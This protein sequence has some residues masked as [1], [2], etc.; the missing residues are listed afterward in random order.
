LGWPF[1]RTYRVC[2]GTSSEDWR[3]GCSCKRT[4][5]WVLHGGT[6]PLEFQF[7]EIL[8]KSTHTY[9]Y[10][11]LIF[12]EGETCSGLS[13]LCYCLQSSRQ[14]EEMLKMSLLWRSRLNHVDFF[15]N[16][17]EMPTKSLYIHIHIHTHTHTHTNMQ[18]RK[19]H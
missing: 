6:H 15:L 18:Y 3:G 8:R 7:Q 2:Q 16:H 14:V 4:R 10:I 9:K 12:K 5:V 13:R 19:L 17:G 1:L 11:F